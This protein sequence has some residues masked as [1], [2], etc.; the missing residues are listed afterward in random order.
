MIHPINVILTTTYAR[1]DIFNAKKHNSIWDSC[2][3]FFNEDIG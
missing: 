3:T 2:Q 1:E